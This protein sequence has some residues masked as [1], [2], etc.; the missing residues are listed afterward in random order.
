VPG[1]LE[2]LR[3]SVV[4]VREFRLL[5]I[6]QAVSSVGDQVFPVAV[7]IAVLNAHGD[8]TDAG[9]VLAARWLALVLFAAIGGV[10]ADRLSRTFLMRAADGFRIAIVVSLALLPSTPPL[11]L[12]AVL[13][14]L[15]GGGEAFFRPA[16]TA[17]LPSILPAERLPSANALI[18][19]SYRT[20]SVIGPGIGA[21]VVTVAGGTRTA[22]A[23]NALTFAVSLFSLTLL[24]EPL[25]DRVAAEDR[26]GVL[27]EMLEGLEEVR[28]RPW[29]GAVLMLASAF[30]MVVLAPATVL[31]PVIGRREFGHDTVYATSLALFAAG[32]VVGALVAIRLK[33]RRPGLV[34]AIGWLPFT[35]VPLVLA[36]PEAPWLFYVAYFVAGAG[37]EPFNIYWQ[38][39]L[40]REIPPDRLARV[41]SLDWMASLSL[42]P[43]G[44]ALTGPIVAALGERPV[45]VFAA[46]FNVASIVP[47]LFVPGFLALRGSR[48]NRGL[49]GDP[50]PAD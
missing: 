43:A 24:H 27:H 9:L 32:G 37:F 40:Q 23:L 5:W 1:T 22:F 39:A 47:V 33:P 45:L 30:L 10:W 2:R 7:T 3:G 49:H 20:A 4:G 42:L 50:Q 48:P 38:S 29:V 17:L 25:R 16:E 26:P 18:T 21:L 46:A 15:V 36:Y 13:V 12:L 35:A 31:L 28:R 44:M 19:I 14:F 41:S 8:A 34:G 6:G 11:W